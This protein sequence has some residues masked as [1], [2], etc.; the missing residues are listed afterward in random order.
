V[1]LADITDPGPQNLKTTIGASFSKPV[2]FKDSGVPIPLT[3]YSGQAQ[4]RDETGDLLAT[5]AVAVDQAVADADGC[6]VVTLSLT[7]TI[8]ESLTIGVYYW[9]MVLILD[10]DPS[11][12]THYVLEGRFTVRPRRTV[13]A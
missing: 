12:N 8:T 5:F 1:S 3:G 2:T 4:I 7:T 9:D 6:G 10:A 11:D 13:V